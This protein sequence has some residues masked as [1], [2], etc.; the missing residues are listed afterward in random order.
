MTTWEAV[1]G[2]HELPP[3]GGTDEAV[4]WVDK[5]VIDLLGDTQKHEV[6]IKDLTT[7]VISDAMKHISVASDEYAAGAD[8]LAEQAFGQLG[9]AQAKATGE[10][11]EEFFKGVIPITP[12]P[13]GVDDEVDKNV[14]DANRLSY[15]A[16]NEAD[17]E[18]IT[19]LDEVIDSNT[20]LYYK[21]DQWFA[22]V[23]DDLH[24]TLWGWMPDL[25]G[26][27]VSFLFSIA[28]SAVF[29]KFMGSFFEETE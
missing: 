10:I 15:S 17:L 11:D 28:G 13:P 5:F 18:F 12:P 22:D 21:V 24:N 29:D 9:R 1:F 20:S 16:V 14:F 7:D 27:S 19:K 23:A 26:A 2:K 3:P 8:I 6:A 25:A 4:T